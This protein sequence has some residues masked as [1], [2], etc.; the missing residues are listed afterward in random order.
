MKEPKEMAEDL[1]EKF[2]PLVDY[3]QGNMVATQRRNAILCALVTIETARHFCN[4]GLLGEY[5]GLVKS[6]LYRII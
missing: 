4:N 5:W 2:L 1:I 3:E 6:E